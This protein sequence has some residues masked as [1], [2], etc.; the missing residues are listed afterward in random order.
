MPYSVFL[1]HS[2]TAEDAPFVNTLAD[3]LSAQGI[4]HY[5]AERDAQFGQ[6][7]AQKIE[8]AIRYCDCFVALLTKG[9]SQSAYVN[10]EIG[11]AVGLGKYII[12]IVEKGVDLVG[13]KQGVEWIEFDRQNPQGC[14]LK[15]LPHMVGLAAAKD[16]SNLLGVLILAGLGL[17]ALSKS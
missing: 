9:G 7:L 16:R 17:W 3:L 12:P 1:S 11:F 5:I 14:L 4:T 15:V 8:Q 6:P 2:M 13:F 10:Q